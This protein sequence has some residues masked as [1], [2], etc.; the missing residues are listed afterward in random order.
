MVLLMCAFLNVS[1][2]LN[3]NEAVLSDGLICL[4]I[5]IGLSSADLHDVCLIVHSCQLINLKNHLLHVL[6]Q[7]SQ[8]EGVV[9]F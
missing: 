7:L 2:S 4:I 6:F 8:Q 9:G 1:L 5:L 3:S